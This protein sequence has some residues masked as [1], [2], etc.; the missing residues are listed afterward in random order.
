MYRIQ[1]ENSLLTAQVEGLQSN[2]MNLQK[3]QKKSNLLLLD[4]PTEEEGGAVIFSPSKEARELEKTEKAQIRKK[5]REQRQ[6][7]AAEKERQKEEQKFAKLADLQLQIDILTTLMLR[8][9]RT[10]P[11]SKK[12][13]A[14]RSGEV[15]E[16]VVDEVITTNRRGRQIRLAHRCR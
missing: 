11:N 9:S 6:R 8:T 1:A 15:E 16:E 5:E 7:E 10:D 3:R 12:S 4:L 14:K 13:K 2:V